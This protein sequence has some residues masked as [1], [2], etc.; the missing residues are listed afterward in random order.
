MVTV[1]QLKDERRRVF[2]KL[3]QELNKCRKLFNATH[4]QLDRRLEGHYTE[5]LDVMDMNA[6][7]EA[8]FQFD[9]QWQAYKT[10]LLNNM[11]AFLQM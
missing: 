7:S 4:R 9:E 1:K 2:R 11:D 6:V 8:A 3:R 5:L 10:I